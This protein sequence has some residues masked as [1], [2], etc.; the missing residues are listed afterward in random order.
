M[1]VTWTPVRFRDDKVLA[2]CGPDG[3]L[4]VEDGMVAF[5]YREGGRTYRTRPDRL[6]REEG[7]P[8]IEAAAGDRAPDSRATTKAPTATSSSSSRPARPGS[9]ELWTDGACSGNP[10]PSG[11]G[12]LLRDGETEHEVSEYL[13]EGTNNIAELTAILRAL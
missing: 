5:C 8:V 4:L 12:V 10:G 11:L 3:E 9:V 7:A 6:G 13:G 2:R 1:V